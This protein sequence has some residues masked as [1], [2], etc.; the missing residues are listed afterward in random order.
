MTAKEP[1]ARSL[2][3]TSTDTSQHQS[4]RWQSSPRR[5]RGGYTIESLM[6]TTKE[7]SVSYCLRRFPTD[8]YNC[9]VGL[10]CLMG[11][12]SESFVT[13]ST[14]K[15]I[16]MC[17]G[18][19]IGNVK[20]S[21]PRA[22]RSRWTDSGNLSFNGGEETFFK[23]MLPGR[24]YKKSPN[25]Q[26][27]EGL[28]WNL[29]YIFNVR[30]VHNTSGQQRREYMWVN[31]DIQV[32]IAHGMAHKERKTQGSGPGRNRKSSRSLWWKRS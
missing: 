7:E 15:I 5:L 30:G 2:G 6:F 1:R 14:I 11:S 26:N 10:M 16:Q 9:I 29:K 31:S 23:P 21:F 27:R 19:T 8:L 13:Q 22:G 18:I 28:S 25:H 32:N 3:L 4:T 24:L 20:W 12:I 17:T